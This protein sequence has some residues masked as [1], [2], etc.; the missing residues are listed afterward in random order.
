MY[1]GSTGKTF[2]AD[3]SHNPKKGCKAFM[4]E[5]LPLYPGRLGDLFQGSLPRFAFRSGVLRA[6]LELPTRTLTMRTALMWA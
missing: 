4:T 1:F 5:L 6:V 3:V 2:A